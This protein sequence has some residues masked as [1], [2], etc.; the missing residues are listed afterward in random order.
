MPASWRQPVFTPIH[1]SP[2]SC[3]REVATS[4]SL[5]QTQQRSVRG[6]GL[7][8]LTGWRRSRWKHTFPG[9]WGVAGYLGLEYPRTLLLSCCHNV[10]RS[11]QIHLKGGRGKNTL[12]SVHQLWHMTL[13]QRHGLVACFP[14][15]QPLPAAASE[16]C[17]LAK[18]PKTKWAGLSSKGEII[19]VLKKSWMPS[20]L[21]WSADAP[22]TSNQYGWAPLPCNGTSGQGSTPLGKWPWNSM[23]TGLKGSKDKEI[24]LT[25]YARV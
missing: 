3:H 4:V 15:S 10:G 24:N 13:G 8:E 21:P 9:E 25:A 18:S 20:F 22:V 16:Y 1:E 14:L 6:E 12:V 19:R 23:Q 17:T 2:Q 11:L 5:K 7:A